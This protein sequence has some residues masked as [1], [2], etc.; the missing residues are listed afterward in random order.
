MKYGGKI[1]MSDRSGK[2]VEERVLERLPEDVKM[3]LN[4][5]NYGSDWH[6]V[7]YY[8]MSV[9]VDTAIDEMGEGGWNRNV[10]EYG[11]LEVV[12]KITGLGFVQE[13]DEDWDKRDGTLEELIYE[14][15][16]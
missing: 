7:A 16:W 2:T 1:M 3:K 15:L 6:E 12:N 14:R 13:G 11:V 9:L 5:L 8:P 10:C 4:V